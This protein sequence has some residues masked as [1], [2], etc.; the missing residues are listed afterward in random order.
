M[1][2][3]DVATADPREFGPQPNPPTVARR[4]H[5]LSG[6]EVYTISQRLRVLR[7]ERLVERRRDGKHMIYRLADCHVADLIHNAFAHASEDHDR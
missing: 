1:G 4:Q 7:S 6:D 2:H 3:R 5:L